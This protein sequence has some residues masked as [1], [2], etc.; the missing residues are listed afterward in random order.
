MTHKSKY[1]IVNFCTS[2]TQQSSVMF[3][4]DHLHANEW[5]T[6]NNNVIVK[7]NTMLCLLKVAGFRTGFHMDWAEAS[8]VSFATS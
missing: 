4:I 2:S 6:F 1:V 7:H 8:N 5:T 3:L